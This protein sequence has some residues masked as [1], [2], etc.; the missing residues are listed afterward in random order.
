MANQAIANKV[1]NGKNGNLWYNG[2]LLATVSK[3]EAKVKGD[4]EDV[5]FCGDGA[6]YTVYNGW[7][8]EGTITIKKVDSTIWADVAAAYLSGTMPDIKLVSSISNSTKASEKV[9]IEGVTITEFT[10]A[11]FEGKKI[12]EEEYPFK[13][14]DYSITEDSL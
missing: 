12:V 1:L 14:S 13:F 5:N 4:F 8:G 10:L 7:T 3:F 11:A 6:T 2:S 9:T